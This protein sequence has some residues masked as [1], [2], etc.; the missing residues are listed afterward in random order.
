[1]PTDDQY[2]AY[3]DAAM[4]AKFGMDGRA[5]RY[6][7]VSRVASGAFVEC[8]LYVSNTAFEEE[9]AVASTEANGSN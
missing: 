7:S 1:M 6:G 9:P 3:V 5:A 8:V 4:Q 2:R